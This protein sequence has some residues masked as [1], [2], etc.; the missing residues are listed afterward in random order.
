MEV[1]GGD[2]DNRSNRDSAAV[3][4]EHSSKPTL[5]FRLRHAYEFELSIEL[6]H[7]HASVRGYR[8]LHGL[9]GCASEATI[10]AKDFLSC[11][12]HLHVREHV[13]L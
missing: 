7:E 9:R 12:L 1:E 11:R 5:Y 2:C 3:A 4:P 10:Q 13:H 6:R 8:H